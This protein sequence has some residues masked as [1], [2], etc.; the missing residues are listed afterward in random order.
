LCGSSKPDLGVVQ[1]S[2]DRAQEVGFIKQTIEVS[3]YADLSLL[4]K[5]VG[6]GAKAWACCAAKFQRGFW[7]LWVMSSGP[8]RPGRR[9]HG[10]P[11]RSL[12][13]HHYLANRLISFLFNL[14][15]NQTL[16]DI[17]SCYKMMTRQVLQSLQLT[18]NDFGIEIEISAKIARQRILRIYERGIGYF[19]RTCA[20]GKKVDWTDGIKALWYVLRCR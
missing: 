17:E 20:E 10:R 1:Q 11:H 15:H 3:K 8:E 18:A 13:F 19:G 14:L 16:S 12:Y 6:A 9:A 4:V 5:R 7:A 2:I